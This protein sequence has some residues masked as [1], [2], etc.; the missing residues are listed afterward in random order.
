MPRGDG[1]INR[2]IDTGIL[3]GAVEIKRLQAELDRNTAAIADRDLQ[4]E[5]VLKAKAALEGENANLK[6]ELARRDS[7]IS[8]LDAERSALE[9]RQAKA[10]AELEQR[11]STK[12]AEIASLRTRLEEVTRAGNA[13]ATVVKELTNVRLSLEQTELTQR[14]S[15]A[16]LVEA[17]ANL[18]LREDQVQR[19]TNDLEQLNRLAADV[20]IEKAAIRAELDVLRSRLKQSYTPEELSGSLNAAIDAF[21]SQANQADPNVQYVINGMDVDL[22]AQVA[23]DDQNRMIFTAADLASKSESALSSIRISIRA[24]PKTTS[25]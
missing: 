18:A 25:D 20:Q 24:V 22:R 13:D 23:R 4:L 2:P 12:D 17:R 5:T 3:E 8:A 19:M 14:R 6:S 15:A 11:V 7:R 1:K 16:D 9:T 21:N 10:V